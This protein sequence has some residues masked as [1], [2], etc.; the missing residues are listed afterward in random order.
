VRALAFAFNPLCDKVEIVSVAGV[1]TDDIKGKD[2]RM[3][4]FAVRF[5]DDEE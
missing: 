4:R 5:N 3:E 2:Y 1:P